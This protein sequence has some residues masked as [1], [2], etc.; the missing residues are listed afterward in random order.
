MDALNA[1]RDKHFG[2]ANANIKK[3]VKKYTE[4][5]NKR[6]NTRRNF[7]I[8]IGERVQVRNKRKGHK[9]R[10]SW[11]PLN[12]FYLLSSIDKTKNICFVKNPKSN[13]ILKKAHHFDD[14]RKYKAVRK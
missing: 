10:A 4:A 3:H 8:K 7:S 1:I 13:Q 5:Y 12:G 2:V 11:K 9:F 14:L 6:N